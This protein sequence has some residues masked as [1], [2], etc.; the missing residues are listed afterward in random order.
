ME[1][2]KKMVY[3]FMTDERNLDDIQIS[4]DA[5]LDTIYLHSTKKGNS[6]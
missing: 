1:E 3:N 2:M 6:V 4:A 5:L